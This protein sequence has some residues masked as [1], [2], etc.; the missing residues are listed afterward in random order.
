ME[1][2]YLDEFVS[3]LI[4]EDGLLAGYE[5]SDGLCLPHFRQALARV[6]DERVFGALVGAQRAI[7]ERLVAHLDEFVRKNDHR[8]QAETWGEERDAWLRAIA[9]LAGARPD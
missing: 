7:W 4:G 9:A 1:A 3:H 6:R 8:F 5:V 2:I